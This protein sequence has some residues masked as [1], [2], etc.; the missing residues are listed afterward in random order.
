MNYP[1]DLSFKILAIASQIYVRDATGN[2]IGYVKQKFFKLKEDINIFADEAQTQLQFNIKAD[3]IID[4][5]AKYTFTDNRGAVLGA[6]K[7]EG[8]RSL[9]RSRYQI[10]NAS[11]NQVMKIAEENGWVKIWDAL[12]G[13]VPILGFFTGYL[14]HPAYLVS[15]MDDKVVARLEKKPA[16]F[17]GRFQL[18][19][20]AS[21]DSVEEQLALLGVLTMTLLERGR[22]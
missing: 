9:W 6:I 5:S 20:L 4:F 1:I 8:M 2:L 7:R 10:F 21:M 22:G 16:F 15:S 3:R 11:G 12:L 17:E 13:E 19:S 18:T 14:F